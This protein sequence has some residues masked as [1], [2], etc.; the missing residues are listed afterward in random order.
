[1]RRPTLP[2]LLLASATV[3]LVAAGCGTPPELNPPGTAVPRPTA[4][5]SATPTVLPPPL[6]PQP[7]TSTPQ[8]PTPTT[9]TGFPDSPAVAC[10]GRPS[11]AQV[12]SLLKR[13]GLLASSYRGRVTVGPM[14]AGTWQW[15][16]LDTANGPLQAVSRITGNTLRLVTAGTDVCSIE[17]RAGAP[18]GIRAAACDANPP[19]I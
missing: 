5:A 9:T 4:T 18:A 10:G 6:T 1:M 7:S 15:S 19:N 16:V 13:R 8:Q 11:A 2:P 17:V 3:A 12:I 14:C